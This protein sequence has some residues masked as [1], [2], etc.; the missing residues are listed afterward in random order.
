M[1][2]KSS[3]KFGAATH[4]G[5]SSSWKV[6]WSKRD[7]EPIAK[8][9]EES[10]KQRESTCNKE[11][12]IESQPKRDHDVKCFRCL[13]TGQITSQCPNKRAMVLC[14]DGEIESKGEKYDNNSMP[15]S[16]DNEDMEYLVTGEFLVTRRALSV[17]V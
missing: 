5:S 14:D 10:H 9:R 6:D 1:K 16:E 3:S 4:S 11:K 2:H 15:P 7:D 17:Q 8:P 13:G 12:G